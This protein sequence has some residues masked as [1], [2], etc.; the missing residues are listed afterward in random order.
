[1]KT[2]L[3][4]VVLFL[5]GIAIAT[6]GPTKAKPPA[7]KI[8]GCIQCGVAQ[9]G[10]GQCATCAAGKVCK[11]C[12]S[13]K[14]T[15]AACKNCGKCAKDGRKLIPIHGKE[16]YGC[17]KCQLAGDTT[18]TCPKCYGKTQP[19]VLTYLCRKC[20]LSSDK[21][22]KCPKCKG[23]LSKKVMVLLDPNSKK[24]SMSAGRG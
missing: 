7:T 23:I 20:E 6:A 21:A 5:L 1:M 2:K 12:K 24:P 17:I 11:E 22:G 10:T 3:V 16:S 9:K 4:P 19:V 13:S 14:P 15:T 18:G 8:V